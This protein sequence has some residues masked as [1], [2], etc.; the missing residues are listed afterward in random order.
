MQKDEEIETHYD[1]YSID[2]IVTTSTCDSRGRLK[3]YS[4]FQMMQDCSEMWLGSEPTVRDYFQRNGMAQLLASR[5]VEIVRV[6]EYKE[7]LTTTTSVF[8]VEAMFG[9][10]NTFITDAEGRVCY[11]T[12][13]MGAFVD[14][15]MG[16]LRRVPEE[17]LRSV[18]L[19][20]KRPMNYADRRI[21]LPRGAELTPC[22]P[23]AVTRNDI[24]YNQ[25]VNNANYIRIAMELLPDGYEPKGVRVEFKRPA[26]LGDTIV[27]RMLV[28]SGVL[29]VELLVG[30]R[31][32]TLIEFK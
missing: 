8:S 20:D 14:R 21:V 11:R 18:K 3:L 17:V 13:S 30:D 1:M 7:R 29:Y 27:P 16:R 6:P 5:Q 26:R 12:W 15:A 2:S 22:E 19:D 9:Y 10:R 24:D 23:V 31:V 4:A 25:H 32:S 28:D